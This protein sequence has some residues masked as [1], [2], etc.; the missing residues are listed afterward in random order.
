VSPV[1]NPGGDVLFAFSEDTKTKPLLPST[2]CKTRSERHGVNAKGMLGLQFI[3]AYAG[4]D[5]NDRDD[6]VGSEDIWLLML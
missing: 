3:R 1:I 5:W 2:A 4:L 6:W